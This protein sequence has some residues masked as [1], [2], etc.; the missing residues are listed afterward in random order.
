MNVWVESASSCMSQVVLVGAPNVGKSSLVQALSSG[1]PEICDYPFTTRSIKMGHFHVNGRRHQVSAVYQA[2][3]CKTPV[4]FGATVRMHP[5]G[6]LIL[7][8]PANSDLHTVKKRS[9]HG[10][11]SCTIGTGSG[12]FLDEEQLSNTAGG[13][14]L[15]LTQFCMCWP[16]NR[17]TWLAG[18]SGRRAQRY[19]TPDAGHDAAPADGGAVRCGPD[20]TVRHVCGRAVA[21]PVCL[22]DLQSSVDVCFW[23]NVDLIGLHRASMVLRP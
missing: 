12:I 21:H 4:V 9:L 18:P 11:Y 8:H 23:P 2:F 5:E 1:L 16:G 19:G 7:P 3:R 10:L 17:Y 14:C 13:A 20:W 6:W 22:P 15:L